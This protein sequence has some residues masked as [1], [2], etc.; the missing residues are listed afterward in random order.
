MAFSE[1]DD[2]NP[3]NRAEPTRICPDCGGQGH[4]GLGPQFGRGRWG[5]KTTCP[6]CRC[7]GFIGP[8]LAA[9]SGCL[10]TL[11]TVCALCVV[12]SLE[13]R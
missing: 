3:M 11:L 2:R 7:T 8:H 6:R 13:G 4:L 1:H 5:L 10:M 12:G 9:G